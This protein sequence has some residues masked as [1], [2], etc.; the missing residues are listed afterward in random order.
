M[1]VARMSRGFEATGIKQWRVLASA[2][3]ALFIRSYERGERVH[4]AMLSRGYTGELP[5]ILESPVAT[6][7][8]SQTLALPVIAAVLSIGRFL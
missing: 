2:A 1:K 3:G 7:I 5:R 4:L 8:W 6:R